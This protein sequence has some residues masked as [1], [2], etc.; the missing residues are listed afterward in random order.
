MLFSLPNIGLQLNLFKSFLCKLIDIWIMFRSWRKPSR[1]HTILMFM[2]EKC[3]ASRQI[4][5]RTEYRLIVPYLYLPIPCTEP[6]LY[7]LIPST[8]SY[9]YL[10]IPCTVPYLYIPTPCTLPYTMYNM[11]EK[12]SVWSRSLRGQNT[13]YTLT[14]YECTSYIV[15]IISFYFTTPL[16]ICILFLF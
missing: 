6:Y 5:Q 7:L 8:V 11:P 9:L 14:L 13:C 4:F 16:I 2:P 12:C 15:P 10:P 1:M 3:S